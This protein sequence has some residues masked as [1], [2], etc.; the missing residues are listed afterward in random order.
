MK[1]QAGH[2]EANKVVRCSCG[3]EIRASDEGKLIRETQSHAEEAHKLSLADEQV[4][5]MME[6]DQ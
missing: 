4:R 5:S 3:V 1:E 2:G 6:V